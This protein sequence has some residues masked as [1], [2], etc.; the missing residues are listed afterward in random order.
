MLIVLKYHDREE[1][2]VWIHFLPSEAKT[3]KAIAEEKYAKGQ[4]PFCYAKNG[5]GKFLTLFDYKKHTRKAA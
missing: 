2:W 1:G 4:R 3:A 5:M